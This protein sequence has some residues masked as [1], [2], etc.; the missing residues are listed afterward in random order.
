M[1]G[2]VCVPGN[3]AHPPNTKPFQHTKKQVFILAGAVL[4]SLGAQAQIAILPKAGVTLSSVSYGDESNDQRAKVGFVGGAGLEIGIVE[5]FFSVQPELLFIRKGERY[6]S[7]GAETKATLNYLELPVLAKLSFGSEAVK[8]YLNAGP[9]LAMGLTGKHKV[10]GGE[11]AGAT[12]T[13]VSTSD[14]S[15]GAAAALPWARAQW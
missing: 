5:N 13:T 14:C 8:G 1:D 9:S 2:F 4:L 3:R 15:S 11:R 6:R 10:E 12:S 7:G